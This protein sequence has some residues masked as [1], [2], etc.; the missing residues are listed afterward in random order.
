MKPPALSWDLVGVP[1]SC[2]AG[3]DTLQVLVLAALG[4]IATCYMLSNCEHLKV[5][6]PSYNFVFVFTVSVEKIDLKGLSHT[7]NDRSVECSFEVRYCFPPLLG[8]I[9]CHFMYHIKS[10]AS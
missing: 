6:L 8:T 2:K 5:L 4:G 3:A 10:F 9:T 1:Q 7:K